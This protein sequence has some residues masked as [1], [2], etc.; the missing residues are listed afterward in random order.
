MS[1]SKYEIFS[2]IVEV[3]SLTKAAE[4]LNLT[5]SGVSYAISTLESEFGFSL[6]KRDRSGI[7]LTSNGERILKHVHRILH[8]EDLLR[9]EAAAIKGFEIGTVRIGTLSSVSTKWLP[10]I[11]AQFN[12]IYPNIEVKTYLGCYDEMNDWIANGTVDF[13]FVSLPI[14]K[15]FETIPLKKDKLM[16][17]L[18]ATHPLSRQRSISYSQI[19]EESF[20]MPQWGS[21]DNIKRILNENK[22]NL[23]IKYE[24]MEE[25]TILAM[26]QRGLGISILPE[27][28][29]DNIPEGV[30]VVDIKEA[31]CRVLGIAA[32]S[33]K[34]ISPAAKKFLTCVRS[35]LREN[36]L[37][38]FE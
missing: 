6:L 22:L 17:I 34:H 1:L 4:K 31:D 12:E 3:G 29:L 32:L 23:Q 24:L 35:W 30:R 8:E 33:W 2:T 16:A 14:S 20:I 36:N 19:K 18:P 13:G 9:Q 10:G 26:V 5:Q 28:I 25:R 15:P 27:L 7:S 21:D 37:L 11:L 38:D